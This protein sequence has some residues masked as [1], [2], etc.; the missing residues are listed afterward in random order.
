MADRA[1]RSASDLAHALGNVIGRGKY[2]SCLLVEQQVIVAEV[3]TGD[4]PVKI[5]GLHI[6]REHIR[7]KNIQC[8]GNVA[9]R[10]RLEVGGGCERGQPR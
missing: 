6:Q 2:L 8:A 1:Q 10:I 7:Q 5:L 4:M 9:H 3:W